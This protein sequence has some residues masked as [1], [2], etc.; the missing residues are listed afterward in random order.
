MMFLLQ[1]GQHN[2][3][4]IQT[5]ISVHSI[6]LELC[7]IIICTVSLLLIRHFYTFV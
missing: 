4:E 3:K 6:L 5:S 2:S 1:Q 7:N